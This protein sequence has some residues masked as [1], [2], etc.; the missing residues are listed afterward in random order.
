[1][2]QTVV[3]RYHGHGHLKHENGIF[4]G[5]F[6]PIHYGHLRSAEEVREKFGLDKIL[7]VPAGSPPLKT[8]GIADA[9]HRQ[10]M[11]RLAVTDNKF[12]ELSDIECR[13]PGKSYTVNT[14]EQLKEANPDAKF[15]FILGIDAFIDIPNWWQPEI[16]ITLLISLLSQAR[17]QIH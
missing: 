10:E 15:F 8:E 13:L 2:K 11:L 1:L 5:T 6:N 7:F 17:I 4:G 12:F 14:I 16:L 3:Y 9:L